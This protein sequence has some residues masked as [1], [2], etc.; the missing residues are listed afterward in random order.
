M[1]KHRER[2]PSD[3]AHLQRDRARRDDQE[4]GAKN[5]LAGLA[6]GVVTGGALALVF[7]PATGE[8]TRA[9]V[10][11]A[12]AQLRDRANQIAEQVRD[13]AG[14]RQ[15]QTQEAVGQLKART[16]S[17]S[18]TAR[19]RVDNLKAKVHTLSPGALGRAERPDEQGGVAAAT[20]GSG[21]A[22]GSAAVVP[23]PAAAGGVTAAGVNQPELGRHYGGDYA[24]DKRDD[25]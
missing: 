17:L 25:T 3:P 5:F 11:D 1:A 13:Q 16:R 15:G 23:P 19:E 21:T 10:V 8:D 12:G 7:A 6:L 24:T 18:G 4:A 9:Q 20:T 22:L 14:A 2:Q